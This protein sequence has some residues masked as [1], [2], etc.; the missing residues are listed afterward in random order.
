MICPSVLAFGGKTQYYCFDC[1]YYWIVCIAEKV[2]MNIFPR[3]MPLQCIDCLPVTKE[4]KLREQKVY[5]QSLK[6]LQSG[7]EELSVKSKHCI[8]LIPRHSPWLN[9]QVRHLKVVSGVRK[10]P[11]SQSHQPMN[12]RA[13]ENTS[14]CKI[15][16]SSLRFRQILSSLFENCI[17][18]RGNGQAITNIHCQMLK[19]NYF[20]CFLEGTFLRLLPLA[21]FLFH[22]CPTMFVWLLL[23]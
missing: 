15:T 23:I 19:I 17:W 4:V 11:T 14:D 2:D 16:A 22:C 6:C 21:T 12:L 7:N 1:F 20:K 8:A 18:E 10:T 9:S 5:Y 13:T 3:F